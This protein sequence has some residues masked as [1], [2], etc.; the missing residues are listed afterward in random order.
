MKKIQILIYLLLFFYNLQCIYS[1][2]VKKPNNLK[3]WD[4]KIPQG[5]NSGYTAITVNKN[6]RSRDIIPAKEAERF[7][8]KFLI[9]NDTAYFTLKAEKLK[10]AKHFEDQ[11]YNDRI[12]YLP[13][14]RKGEIVF[15]EL[16]PDISLS[17][18]LTLFS[19][20]PGMTSFKF[21]DC[22]DNKLFKYKLFEKPIKGNISSG[23]LILIYIDDK[24]NN[25]EKLVNK[26]CVNNLIVNSPNKNIEL[27]KKIELCMLIHYKIEDSHC[28]IE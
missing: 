26:Y 8:I 9:E 1:Q 16:V 22:P 19:Y 28:V 2:D 14:L 10:Y 24:D 20:F 17:N 3:L 11:F 23:A 7:K 27:L 5:L 4:F 25:V 6:D 13:N 21:M 12:I 18:K 15:F